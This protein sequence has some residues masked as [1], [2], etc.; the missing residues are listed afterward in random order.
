MSFNGVSG[1]TIT[2]NRQKLS[3]GSLHRRPAVEVVIEHHELG[4]QRDEPRPVRGHP[5][6]DLPHGGVRR[7]RY[8]RPMHV[9]RWRSPGGA[10]SI[11]G[12]LL[13]M[14]PLSDRVGFSGQIL[15]KSTAAVSVS[16]S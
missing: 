10:S 8:H 6:G 4:A 14:R 1:L 12:G 5:N 2:G 16:P 3:S 7:D 9:T 11:G 15:F 13:G